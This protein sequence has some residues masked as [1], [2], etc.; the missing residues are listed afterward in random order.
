MGGT[1][2]GSLL[3]PRFISTKWNP[4]RVYALIELGIGALGLSVLAFMPFVSALYVR[5]FLFRGAA[6]AICLLPPT[7]LMGATLPTL[8]RRTQISSLGYLYAGNIAGGV[9]GCLL[10]GFY[11]LRVYDVA[12]ATYVA[13]GINFIV[14]LVAFALNSPAWKGLSPSDVVKSTMAHS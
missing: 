8:A 10:A 12:V 4:L 14:A 6:A 7:L 13:A 2:V 9:A 5:G 3:F 1:C 11:L